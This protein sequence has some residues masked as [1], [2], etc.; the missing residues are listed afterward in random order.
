VQNL[1]K[2]N[3]DSVGWKETLLWEKLKIL[4]LN[5]KQRFLLR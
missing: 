2:S 4:L 3:D 5:T 1:D